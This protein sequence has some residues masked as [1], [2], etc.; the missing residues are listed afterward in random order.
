[1]SAVVEDTLF[2]VSATHPGHHRARNEDALLAM[3]HAGLW[4]VA[5][6]MGGHACGDE[7]S[8]AVVEALYQRSE[9]SRGLDLLDAIPRSLQ[10]VNSQLCARGA[11]R[12]DGEPIGTTVVALALEGAD[13]HC[14]WA[15]DSRLYLLRD[16]RLTALTRDHSEPGD[17]A[18][19][20]A[21][22]R[23]VGAEPAL[24]VDYTRGELYED[25]LFLLCSD[26]LTGVVPDVAIAHTLQHAPASTA[27][28]HLVQQA[29]AAG[30]PDNI[31]CVAVFVCGGSG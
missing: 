9:E 27:C 12:G 23:A 1:M 13:Y 29:L 26:G 2:S 28:A 11:A 15:G 5:D 4:A 8:E 31:T 3:D 30:G 10:Q 24:A 7:A 21:L 19:R 25:D 22:T 6:G 17:S 20:C 18:G 16:G 14:F